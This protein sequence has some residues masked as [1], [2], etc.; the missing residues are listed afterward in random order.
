VKGIDEKELSWI[1]FEK[2]LNFFYLYERYYDEN[3]KDFY[4]LKL[5]QCI[6][7]EYV[8]KFLELMRYVPYIKNT[9]TKIQ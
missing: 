3:T 6:I 8:K 9:K 7:D 2:Y 5:G 4:E 1:Q